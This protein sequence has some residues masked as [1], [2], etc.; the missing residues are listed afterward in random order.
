MNIG[1][2]LLIVS[3]V[4]LAAHRFSKSFFATAPSWG[5]GA[6]LSHIIN[7]GKVIRLL[8]CILVS[9]AVIAASLYVVLSARYD[10]A[11][12]KWAF[13]ALGAQVGYWMRGF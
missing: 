10:D 12:R 13:G 1:M 8:L 11:T 4:I 9:L 2:I 3:I 5:S 6:Q 7:W